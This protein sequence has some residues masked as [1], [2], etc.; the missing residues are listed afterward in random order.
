MFRRLGDD[1]GSLFSG[2]LGA[3]TKT[4][5][6]FEDWLDD[7]YDLWES[8]IGDVVSD[9]RSS[10]REIVP[11]ELH[12]EACSRLLPEYERTIEVPA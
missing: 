5:P 1:F 12:A 7:H 9:W 8:T 6:S 4:V 10:G 11:S 3:P 2:L